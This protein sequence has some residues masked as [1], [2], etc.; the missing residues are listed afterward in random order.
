MAQVKKFLAFDLGAES[1][2]VVLG[3]FDGERLRLSEVH[4]FPN[5]QV[6]L[7]DGLHWDVL[8]LWSEVKR[9]LALAVQEYGVDLAGVGLDTWGVDFGLLDRDG[10][11]VANPYHYR[12][13]RTDG[14]IEEAFRRV[15][16]EEIFEQ[17]GIQFMQL[18]SLYQLLA[19]V[20]GRSPALDIAETFL[21]MPD[22]FNYWLTGRKV[23]EF[24]IATTTQCYDPRKGDW[25]IPLL[26]QLG[27]PAHIFPEIV[28]PGTVL[29]ELLPAV[30]EEVGVSGL[31][32][33]APACHDTG[34]A[35]AAVPAEGPDF[36][37][38]SSGTWSL[39]GAELP[40]PVIN[41]QSL[42]F[43]FTNEGGVGGTFR[44]LKN[45]AG[46]WLVQE[47]R[48]TW[49]RQD[50]EFSYDDLTQMA[51]QATPLQSVVDP[52]YAEFLKPGDMPT[53]I[54]AFC[55]R[56]GQPVPQSKG[57]VIRC[58]LESLA[59]KY[60]WVLERL[61]EILGRLLEP[62]HI[63]GGGTQNWLLNQFAADATGRR[64]I[65]GPIEATAAGNVIMQAMA[66]GHI[67]SLEEGRQVVR[68]SFDVVTYEP[69]GEPGWDEAYGRFLAMME[70]IG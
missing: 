20:V 17:T 61:E 18:N 68:N 32:V 34:C 2:R 64:V 13:S 63:V 10:A 1:G 56:T 21:T 55:E 16:R 49:A 48:R 4:R 5:G 41:E 59:L 6:R 69:A 57:A 51:A 42:T 67:G 8:R 54:R 25:A 23:C 36:V 27:I 3:Q 47:C 45:I 12:D 39:M 38:I 44:F 66:L 70:Q 46:L 22:L 62:I 31:P 40:E 19:M 50:E 65:A 43:D 24:S 33:I 52:D 14:M 60:R 35:V 7:P 15:P 53:R 28:P 30:A 26:E 37:Y 29:G 58:V 9:G 11:L